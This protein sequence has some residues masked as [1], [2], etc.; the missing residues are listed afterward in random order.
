MAHTQ[1]ELSKQRQWRSQMA[2]TQSELSGLRQWGSEM[3]H[4]V[5][6]E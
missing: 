3:V 5:T 6:A 2:L 4:K 1:S